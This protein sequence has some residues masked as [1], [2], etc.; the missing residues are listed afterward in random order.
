MSDAA[1]AKERPKP[2]HTHELG[3]PKCRWSQNGCAVCRAKPYSGKSV[4][5]PPSERPRQRYVRKNADGAG[6]KTSKPGKKRKEREPETASDEEYEVVDENVAS[7]SQPPERE[8]P[9]PVSMKST[10][11]EKEVVVEEVVIDVTFR[12][13]GRVSAV[14][15]RKGETAQALRWKSGAT[16]AAHPTE[17]DTVVIT[18][19][20]A[21]VD[22]A[23]TLI[24]EIIQQAE[25]K[26]AARAAVG[27]K[28]TPKAS[29]PSLDVMSIV[30]EIRKDSSAPSTARQIEDDAK[31]SDSA[32]AKLEEFIVKLPE[33]SLSRTVMGQF[34]Q[35]ALDIAKYDGVADAC[36][37]ALKE[38][39][40][41]TYTP[42]TERLTLFYL[43]DSIAQASRVEARGGSHALHALFARAL[44]RNIRELIK[45]MIAVVKVDD[46]QMKNV[47]V[48]DGATIS[49]AHARHRRKAVQ[50]V[51]A[52]WEG[53]EV[54][55]K[56]QISAAKSTISEYRHEN[57]QKKA[58]AFDKKLERQAVPKV[59]VQADGCNAD[60]FD[61]I[62]AMLG[63]QYG[64]VQDVI[65]STGM[66]AN[67][68]S[69]RAPSNETSMV[70][71]VAPPSSAGL[72][73]NVTYSPGD[74]LGSE[75]G[76]FAE[77]PPPPPLPTTSFANPLGATRVV[78]VP[79]PPLT[80]VNASSPPRFTVDVP[81]PPAFTV[82]VPPPPPP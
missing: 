44:S 3:C 39:I 8:R 65:G 63:N 47:E 66:L 11:R 43:I 54:L 76:E 64:S 16:V 1:P 27:P 51:L 49:E 80:P 82:D 24:R 30:K 25:E 22:K 12:C 23:K 57:L 5:P 75:S 50:K 56:T 40:E 74:F 17:E 28:P 21:K 42:A 70:P 36:I 61:D 60:E 55:S 46:A 20:K 38:R 52:I 68:A 15:G 79:P 31:M 19:T 48:P 33:L 2:A 4:R 9:A 13:G 32:K 69:L 78:N 14:I 45:A 58:R 35:E 18:G 26:A 6:K 34:T 29:R 37:N 53:R 67:L 7:T 59:K 62:A 71:S 72:S 73:E 41:A 81:P 10:E 77:V